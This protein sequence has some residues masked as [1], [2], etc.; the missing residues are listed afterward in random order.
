MSFPVGVDVS[1]FIARMRRLAPL[2]SIRFTM[3][4]RSPTL[5]AKRSISW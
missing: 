3:L 4:Q 5:L 1:R 2:L